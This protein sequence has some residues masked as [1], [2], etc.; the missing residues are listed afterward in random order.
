[1]TNLE[2][3]KLMKSALSYYASN[4]SWELYLDGAGNHGTDCDAT[5]NDRGR[6]AR[7]ALAQLKTALELEAVSPV[8]QENL[9]TVPP[10]NE[11]PKHST[12]I[13]TT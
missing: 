3:I 6:R 5:A 7:Q 1:M 10:V 9:P 13:P 12:Q 8:E 2:A 11:D 4:D